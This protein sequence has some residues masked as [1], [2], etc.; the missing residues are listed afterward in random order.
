MSSKVFTLTITWI[1]AHNGYEGN[2]L[3]NEYAK[4]ATVN[5]TKHVVTQTTKQEIK[6]LIETKSNE[7]WCIKWEKYKHCRQTKCFHPGPSDS[8]YKLVSKLSRSAMATF[9]QIITGQNNLNYITHKIIP[10]HTDLCRFCEEEEET[11]IHLL[12]ECPVFNAYRLSHLKGSLELGTFK[13]HPREL[14]DLSL[15]HI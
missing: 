5:H 10:T 11:F 2:E 13:W 9:I 7:Y 15:I 3:A 6:N 4:Q 12:N 1:K 8:M 14:L